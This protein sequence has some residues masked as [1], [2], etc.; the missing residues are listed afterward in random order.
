MT[1]GL[2]YARV[3][4]HIFD[5]YH[6]LLVWKIIGGYGH[7]RISDK[8]KPTLKHFLAQLGSFYEADSCIINE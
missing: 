1:D 3:P 7:L 8:F 2:E 5:S 4:T 6:S